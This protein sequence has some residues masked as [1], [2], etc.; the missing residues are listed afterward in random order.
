[1][2][3]ICR[4]TFS[5]SAVTARKSVGT[6]IFFSVLVLN[7]NLPRCRLLGTIVLC[8]VFDKLY[9]VVIRTPIIVLE[10]KSFVRDL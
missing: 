7:I 9:G 8:F 10:G 5:F 3:V 1:M 4:P 2:Y 6:H